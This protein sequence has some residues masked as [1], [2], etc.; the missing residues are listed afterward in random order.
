MPGASAAAFAA[1]PSQA[2]PPVESA[3]ARRSLDAMPAV[4]AQRRSVEAP[5]NI[6]DRQAPLTGGSPVDGVAGSADD[7]ADDAPLT[8]RRP[9]QD[10]EGAAVLAPD[11]GLHWRIEQGGLFYL[12]NLLNL[13]W[14]RNLL[15]SDS[16]A[17]DFP[18]AWGWLYRLGEAFGLEPE[19][20]LRQCLATLADM[21]SRDFP[22]QLPALDAAA[23]IIDYGRQRYAGF[24]IWQ[25]RLL[26]Q[27]ARVVYRRPELDI[28]FR[29]GELD[30]RVRRAAL[31]VDPGWV[32]WLATRVRFHYR[33]VL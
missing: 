11:T 25:T 19:P 23:D 7:R 27:A 1:P 28:H 20:A 3:T 2:T 9:P 8:D 30:I 14:S 24:G 15:F 5:P 21:P 32:D 29:L 10:A 4:E 26:S 13:P 17:M 31:D 16:A 6:T 33:D 12:L 22:D 18:S